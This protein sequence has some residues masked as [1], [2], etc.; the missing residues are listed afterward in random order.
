MTRRRLLRSAGAILVALG[1]GHLALAVVLTRATLLGWAAGGVWAAVPLLPG[2]PPAGARD[3]LAFWGGP[4]G[5]AVPL[6]TLGLLLWHLAG[7]GVRVPAFVGWITA[8]WCL[9]GAV[10]LVP[11]P[12]VVGAVAGMLVVL[13]ARTARWEEPV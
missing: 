13:S 2:A 11:S 12:F 4:G 5:F 1:A 6:V 9:V 10:L 7:R 3:A 8:V